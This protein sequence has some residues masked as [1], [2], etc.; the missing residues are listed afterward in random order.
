[1][2]EA[3]GCPERIFC[4]AMYESVIMKKIKQC[5]FLLLGSWFSFATSNASAEIIYGTT[6][7]RQL[8]SFDSAAPST[9][10]SNVP[11]T[12]LVDQ[13]GGEQIAGIDFRVANGALYAWGNAPGS[14]YRLYTLDTSTGVATRV[15][16]NTDATFAGTF[17]GFDF[18][19]A[20]DRIRIIN[21]TN[22]S[23]RYNP[24]TG[25]LAGTDTSLNPGG[26]FIAAAYDRNDTDLSTA[27]TMFA[28]DA[29]SDTL[30][31]VGDVNGTPNSPN[32][33]IVT[34]IGA[35]GVNTAN[36][37]SFDISRT[38]VAYAAL[39]PSLGASPSLY[40]INLAT[41]AASLVGTIGDGSLIGLTGMSAFAPV[42]VPEPSCVMLLGAGLL[43]GM[44]RRRR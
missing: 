28:I 11:I 36:E 30:V 16:G 38:G 20:A 1:M 35:L 19:P 17:W 9:L 42:P 4:P 3:T 18:N 5:A 14:T 15:P 6:V 39:S 34:T 27:T 10:V 25:V 22:L 13:L 21:D 26:N 7:F 2:L 44:V 23:I 24:I 33:G 31:R 43:M 32:T 29:T 40:T 8:I 41:G 12:G 37:T